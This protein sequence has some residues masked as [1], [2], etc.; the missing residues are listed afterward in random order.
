MKDL[1]TSSTPTTQCPKNWGHHLFSFHSLAYFLSRS[2]YTKP[3]RRE[4]RPFTL[5]FCDHLHD[6]A[7]GPQPGVAARFAADLIKCNE[8]FSLKTNNVVRQPQLQT[9]GRKEEQPAM[10]PRLITIRGVNLWDF[11]LL[12]LLYFFLSWVLSNLSRPR[13]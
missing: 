3:S 12:F 8:M 1:S 11:S 10:N 7:S 5:A 6:L 13:K 2:C 9:L 4:N